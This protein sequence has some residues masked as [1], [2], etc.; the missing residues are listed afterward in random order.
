M[1]FRSIFLVAL[2]LA[3]GF[4]CVSAQDNKDD[5]II[6]V[7]TRLV[8][9]PV[10]VSDRD[11]RYV[12]GLT[13]KD[14]AIL[15]NGV[16]QPIEFFGAN[17]EP[18]T[19]AL[20]IDTSHSTRP[21]LDD[22]K[23]A[24]KSFIKL[25]GLQDQAMI[26]SFDHGTHILSPLTGDQEK[27]RRAVKDAEIPDAIGTTLRDALFQTVFTSFEGLT[28]RKAI[29][30]LT[31][32]RDGGSHVS[33][34]ELLTRLQETD[35]MVYT[36]QF[37]TEEKLRIGQMLKTG[38]IPNLTK[39]GA[40]RRVKEEEK[41]EKAGDFMHMISVV[42]AGR[43][44]STE[45]GNLKKTFDLIV[46]EL[47]R[48]Y[49]LGFYPPENSSDKDINEVKVRIARPNLIVRARGSYRLQAPK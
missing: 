48:Q 28:G 40:A 42:T 47:R 24:A 22:I 33:E 18:L 1:R 21:V 32:G 12:P 39:S 2:M 6:K 15:Q 4:C 43:F 49:R 37:R 41:V 26:V 31:D 23:D 34:N 17:D 44:Y 46:D 38:K 36:V 19:I 45:S 35:T 13:Q 3:A 30:L 8:S 25:L 14:F 16:V 11:G 9:V 7:E 20:L 5:E 27:L 10:I 29:I